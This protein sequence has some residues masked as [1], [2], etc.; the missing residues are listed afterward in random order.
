MQESVLN[1]VPSG[2]DGEEYSSLADMLPDIEKINRN[3]L[4]LPIKKAGENIQD[5]EIAEFYYQFL[6]DA[7][8]ENE[9]N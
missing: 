2:A 1:N 5:K 3:A 6:K 8:W 7:G 4:I 9:I